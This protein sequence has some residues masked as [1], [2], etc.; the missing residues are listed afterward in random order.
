M[1]SRPGDWALGIALA[2]LLLVAPAAPGCR[3]ARDAGTPPVVEPA[4][5]GRWHERVVTTVFWV[6]E[7]GNESSAWCERWVA[8]YGGVD[9]P[10]NRKGWHPAGFTP[11]E[12]PFYCALPYSDLV[13]KGARARPA[14]S[15]CKNRWIQIEFR[16]KRCFAQWE[17]AGPYNADDGEYVFGGRPHRGKAGLDVSPAVRD[18]LGLSGRDATRWRF[19]GAKDVPEGPWKEIVTTSGPNWR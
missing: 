18:L 2:A 5:A 6:G 10:K 7:K 17:D 14:R 11:K 13:S 15:A 4:R 19:V 1:R 16:G 12:N 9:D 8:A 3:P